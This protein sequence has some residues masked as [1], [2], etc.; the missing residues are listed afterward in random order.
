[1]AYMEPRALPY[2]EFPEEKETRPGVRTLTMDKTP[3]ARSIFRM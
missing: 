3:T 1:M 2:E